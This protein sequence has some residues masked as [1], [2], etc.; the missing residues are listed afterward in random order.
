MSKIEDIRDIRAE[1]AAIAKDRALYEFNLNVLREAFRLR[2]EGALWS[3]RQRIQEYL[4][5]V[6]AKGGRWA[7]EYALRAMD[8][9]LLIHK[10]QNRGVATSQS[11]TPDASW[12]QWLR[13]GRYTKRVK[14]SPPSAE[15]PD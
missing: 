13:H 8:I 4:S 1:K 2:S 11:L 9:N 15:S 3:A 10:N 12:R 7:L 6:L 5:E 14:N